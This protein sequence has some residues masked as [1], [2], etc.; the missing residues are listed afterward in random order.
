MLRTPVRLH[1][2]LIGKPMPFDV[3]DRDG[4]LLL[5]RGYVIE[6]EQEK[7]K[8]FKLGPERDVSTD[9]RFRAALA[10]A[11]R[12][13]IKGSEE[14]KKSVSLPFTELH[15]L[16]GEILQIKIEGD[17]QPLWSRYIGMVRNKSLLIEGI[18]RN[19]VAIFVKEGSTIQVKGTSGSY[20]FL[21]SA[22]VLA[23]ISRPFPYHHL[24]YPSEV[25]ALRLRRSERVPVRIV[26]AVITKD[27]EAHGGVLLD[28][29]L[30]GGLLATRHPLAVGE[31]ITLKF[32]LN[33]VGSELILS[34]LAE[35]R[36]KRP[37]EQTRDGDGYG[38]QFLD[39]TPEETLALLTYI[40]AVQSGAVS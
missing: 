26:C 3:Y 31:Q 4:R 23:N 16:P 25:R 2:L 9:E 15:L 5:R 35:V 37:L 18:T 17:D 11:G 1:E 33:L 39:M 32:K 6:T 14:G 20:A 8:L 34:V 13:D 29:S 27:G 22:S 36:S 38:V 24:T 30:G 7:Q 10:S 28:L 21:F 40:Q 12:V 19:D